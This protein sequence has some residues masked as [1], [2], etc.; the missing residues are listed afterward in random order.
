MKPKLILIIWV[1]LTAGCASTEKYEG[2]LNLPPSEVA[3]I[4]FYR[5]KTLFRISDPEAPFIYLDGKVAAKLRVGQSKTIQVHPGTYKLSVREPI[6]FMPSYESGSFEYEFKAGEIYYVR[7]SKDFSGVYSTTNSPV[8]TGS[9]TFQL[10][11]KENYD[12]KQ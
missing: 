8:V 9:S 2:N 4:N 11:T 3:T 1:L 6:L 10:T 7:Y 12:L 5:T